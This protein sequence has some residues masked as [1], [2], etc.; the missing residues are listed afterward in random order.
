MKINVKQPETGVTETFLKQAYGIAVPKAATGRERL[1]CP[2]VN[3]RETG[4]C[5][6]SHYDRIVTT[7]CI[8]FPQLL[9]FYFY[10][11]YL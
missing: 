8:F 6:K 3:A 10:V 2:L 11:L 9:F 4:N 7:F 5:L 1:P